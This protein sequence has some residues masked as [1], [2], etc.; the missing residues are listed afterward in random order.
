MGVTHGESTAYRTDPFFPS[1]RTP[2]GS[3]PAWGAAPEGGGGGHPCPP[4]PPRE[5]PR[6]VELLVK[7][8]PPDCLASHLPPPGS[9]GL[10]GTGCH[11][12][13][14][15]DDIRGQSQQRGAGDQRGQCKGQGQAAPS[16]TTWRSHFP[17]EP[18]RRAASVGHTAEQHGRTEAHR[19][20]KLCSNYTI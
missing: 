2:S 8:S 20:V 13:S 1:G 7:G 18:E 14:L 4:D 9:A 16:C 15:S 6:K 3:G 11:P 12:T 17:P 10:G 5:L 19:H